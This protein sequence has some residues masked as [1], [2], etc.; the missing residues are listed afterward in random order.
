MSRQTPVL[1]SRRPSA[2]PREPLSAALLIICMTDAAVLVRG[3]TLETSVAYVASSRIARAAWSLSKKEREKEREEK[4]VKA[5][6]SR[7][8]LYSGA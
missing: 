5:G 8:V 7:C 2:A 1:G 6:E 4:G 3:F